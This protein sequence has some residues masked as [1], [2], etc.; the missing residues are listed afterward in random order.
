[1]RPLFDAGAQHQATQ[2][3]RHI[4]NQCSNSPVVMY[5]G[6]LRQPAPRDETYY[7]P[8]FS[9]PAESNFHALS[10]EVTAQSHS[11]YIAF[12]GSPSS[13]PNARCVRNTESSD[14]SGPHGIRRPSALTHPFASDTS[15]SVHK[16]I[17]A[18]RVKI[19]AFSEISAATFGLWMRSRG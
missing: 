17:S 7:L 16:N 10:K 1:V 9:S 14:R 2:F 5:H 12:E 8:R 3:V 6:N 19:P 13:L 15:V 18:R 4:H 11:S